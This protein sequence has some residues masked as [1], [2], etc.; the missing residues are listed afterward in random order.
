MATK[1]EAIAQIEKLA[2]SGAIPEHTAQSLISDIEHGYK[3]PSYAVRKAQQKAEK[4][5][6]ERPQQTAKRIM[7]KQAEK[8]AR[9]FVEKHPD[10]RIV[11]DKTAKQF[12][13]TKE[14][15]TQQLAKELI[16]K[17]KIKIEIPVK[18]TV[19][20]TKAVKKTVKPEVQA[21]KKQEKAKAEKRELP[22]M[23]FA[24]GPML[25]KPKTK[26]E[27]E[28]ERRKIREQLAGKSLIQAYQPPLTYRSE[29]SE[30]T[31][32][33]IE[34]LTPEKKLAYKAATEHEFELKAGELYIMPASEEER[35]SLRMQQKYSEFFEPV[36]GPAGVV[37]KAWQPVVSFF[38]L[39]EAKR[40][41]K[42][43][44]KQQILE[45]LGFQ[46]AR[47]KKRAQNRR[48]TANL[49]KFGQAI[50]KA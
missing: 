9:E 3:E 25:G 8:Q 4:E 45:S 17:G 40:E 43:E 48:E 32:P 2:S 46:V 35:A 16:E 18:T 20:E 47:S 23:A 30:Y 6:R 5:A 26:E 27:A 33:R 1:S 12:V 14:Y 49:G 34:A 28:A 44:E 39:P 21:I 31:R 29:R 11:E 36:S 10:F 41:L 7:Q 50:C 24:L 15:K 37:Q 19:T 22:E 38:K 42:I 13:G